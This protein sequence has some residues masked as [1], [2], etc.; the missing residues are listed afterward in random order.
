MEL[1]T[2]AEMYTPSIDFKG[3]YIDKIPPFTHG[4]R[5]LCGARR[6]KVYETQPLFASHIKS[7]SHQ[8]WL[9]TLN[10]NRANYYVENEELKKIIK[11]QKMLLA[12]NE[13]DIKTKMKTIDFLTQQLM[14]N[15]V[16]TKTV[17]NLLD[18]D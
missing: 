10:L 12:Q 16:N 18:F 15:G 5:C 8:K 3:N 6:E 11:Q 13:K 7:K 9:E 1:V 17:D 4:L 14:A 2:E